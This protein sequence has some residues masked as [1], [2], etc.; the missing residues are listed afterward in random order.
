MKNAIMNLHFGCQQ[1]KAKV[2]ITK[3]PPR[4]VNYVNSKNVLRQN[5]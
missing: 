2:R 1:A 5:I 3:S 4:N